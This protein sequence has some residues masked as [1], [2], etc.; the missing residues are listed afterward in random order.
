MDG[1]TRSSFSNTQ[2]GFYEKGHHIKA[3]NPFAI[4]QEIVQVNIAKGGKRFR[5]RLKINDKEKNFWSNDSGKGT[6]YRS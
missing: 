3:Y 6:K 5:R 2:N 4:R 1:K